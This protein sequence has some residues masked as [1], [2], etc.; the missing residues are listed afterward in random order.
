[1]QTRNRVAEKQNQKFMYKGLKRRKECDI[2]L[3]RQIEVLKLLGKSRATI[4]HER[5]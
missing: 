1:M 2:E 5:A 3:R 4:R